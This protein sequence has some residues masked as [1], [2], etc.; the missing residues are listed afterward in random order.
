[1]ARNKTDRLLTEINYDMLRHPEWYKPSDPWRCWIERLQKGLT[2]KTLY[3]TKPKYKSWQIPTNKV[4]I[5]KRG[6]KENKQ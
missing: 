4:R 5:W 1:M 2:D 3:M 6:T